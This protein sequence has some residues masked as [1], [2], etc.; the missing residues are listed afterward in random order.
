MESIS[1]K[2]EDK[3]SVQVVADGTKN[4]RQILNL[5]YSKIDISKLTGNSSL[6]EYNPT[7]HVK[8]F[9]R[10][11]NISA[12]NE[13]RFASAMLADISQGYAFYLDPGNESMLITCNFDGDSYQSYEITTIVPTANSTFTLYY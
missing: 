1:N 13:I 8:N 11:T 10:I 5:L 2:G 3:T 12:Y 6:V 4:Y 9:T 7:T